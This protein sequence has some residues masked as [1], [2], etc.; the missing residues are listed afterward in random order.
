MQPSH[1]VYTIEIPVRI[2][3]TVG[4][5]EAGAL[6]YVPVSSL[7]R[8]S[9]IRDKVDNYIAEVLAGNLKLYSKGRAIAHGSAQVCT[10]EIPHITTI[11]RQ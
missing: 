6:Y 9:E 2:T 8:I 11:A 4:S 10:Y 5:L 7:D 3:C 1:G